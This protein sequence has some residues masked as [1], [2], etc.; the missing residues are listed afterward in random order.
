[1]ESDLRE[2]Y[3]RK[4]NSATK[5]RNRFTLEW[6]TGHFGLDDWPRQPQE[7]FRR[8][9]RKLY[10]GASTQQV[11]VQQREVCKAPEQKVSNHRGPRLGWPERRLKSRW[12]KPPDAVQQ[13]LLAL[14]HPDLLPLGCQLLSRVRQQLHDAFFLGLTLF[15]RPL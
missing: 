6:L 1:M 8:T 3:I 9:E 13:P 7:D 14:E 2:R 4:L 15:Q 12:E 11:S 10:S 5:L